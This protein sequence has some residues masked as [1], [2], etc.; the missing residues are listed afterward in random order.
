MFCRYRGLIL[1]IAFA[2]TVA[3]C[4]SLHAA[5]PQVRLA[6]PMHKIMIQGATEGFPF[7]SWVAD[8]YDLYLARY[9]HEAFQVVVVPETALTNVSV[10]VGT[11]VPQQAQGPFSGE[12]NVNLVGYVDVGDVTQYA[13]DYPSYLAGYHGWWPDALL[14]FQQTCDINAGD[15]VPF[16]VDVFTYEDTPPGDYVATV[17]VTADGCD[18]VDLQL[19]IHVWDF[20]LPV[21]SHLGTAFSLQPDSAQIIYGDDW[22]DAMHY[23]FFDIMLEHRLNVT[24]LYRNSTPTPLDW[25]Q[26][27]V[28]NGSNAFSLGKVPA[29]M[30]SQLDA[31]VINLSLIHI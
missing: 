25:I 5:A 13:V 23:K 2:W 29:I 30:G 6:T 12:I 31:L 1:L 10:S 11:P 14:E 17:T 19:N 22:S 16:W 18:P 20:E 21:S 3:A 26:Y 9:E 8:H 4:S 7:E 24:E 27:W 28:A 15:R